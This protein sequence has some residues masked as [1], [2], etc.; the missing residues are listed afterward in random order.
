MNP[1]EAL[2]L[3]L[4][5]QPLSADQ[6]RELVSSLLAGETEPLC[7]AGLLVALA[8]RGETREEITGAALAMRSA[9]VPFEH[10]FPEAIDTCGTGGSGL[11]TFNV[12]TASAIVAAAGGARVIKHGNRSASSRC[13]SADL[14]EKL[15]VPLE[16]SP[17][18]ARVVLEE[19]GI[20]FLF[21]PT[22]H[23]AVRHAGPIRRALGVRTIFNLLGP[24]CNPGGVTRQLLGVF[25][26]SRVEDLATVLAELG[27]N[28]AL[29][30]HG[31]GGADELT[32]AGQNLVTAVGDLSASGFD[33]ADLS[34]PI[35][36]VEASSGGDVD[37]NVATLHQLF[38]GAELPARNLVLLNSAA[39]LVV[40]G[41]ASDSKEGYERAREAIDSGR[42]REIL[43]RW[44]SVA[45]AQG[46]ATR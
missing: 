39:A 21:A 27:C 20:T 32:L 1:Q 3:V 22:Y 4:S 14:L 8:Q 9:M 41:I 26:P 5:G 28:R 29:V 30:V 43:H 36:R 46:G 37:E 19:V 13:G 33:P 40:A 35:Q 2:R 25:D 10:E 31:G 45:A 18:A 16:L 34:L 42:A 23:P 11:D 12:S 44:V 15:G 6:T 7:F 17:P 38:E 24:L